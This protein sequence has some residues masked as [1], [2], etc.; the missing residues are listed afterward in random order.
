MNLSIFQEEEKI[1]FIKNLPNIMIKEKL[2]KGGYGDVYHIETK[3]KNNGSLAIKIQFADNNDEKKNDMFKNECLLSKTL[4]HQNIINTLLIR[5]D[6]INH[7]NNNNIT[8]YSMFMEKAVYHNLHYFLEYFRNYNLMKITLNKRDYEYLIKPNSF[9]IS[10]FI[11]QIINGLEILYESN[12]VHRDIKLQNILCCSN[13][14]LKICD[15]GLAKLIKKEDKNFHLGKSTWIYQCPESYI[16]NYKINIKDSF[17]Q[18]YFSLG[19]ILYYLI[20]G[21]H[22]FLKKNKMNYTNCINDIRNGKEKINN[23]VKNKFI[24]CE[25]GNIANKLLFENISDSPSIIEIV[26]NKWIYDNQKEANKI[27]A[28]NQGL[29]IKFFIEMYKPKN[30]NR[31]RNKFT[32]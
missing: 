25:L 20:F 17:N 24:D 5:K 32:V 7:N 21:E 31:R 16:N 3:N 6:I 29:E 4:K 12:V 14:I 26:D 19:I 28:I 1:K 13:F 9:F 8:M 22:L 23:M 15:F 27:K 30:N 18:D 10:Y 11:F 2:G